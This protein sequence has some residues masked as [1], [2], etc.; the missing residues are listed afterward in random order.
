M[1]FVSDE[2]LLNR[3]AVIP[4]LIWQKNEKDRTE[5]K[6]ICKTNGHE[7]KWKKEVEKKTQSVYMCVSENI[8]H[9]KIHITT[10]RHDS[11]NRTN[12]MHCTKIDYNGHTEMKEKSRH[13]NGMLQNIDKATTLSSIHIWNCATVS[14]LR[15]KSTSKRRNHGVWICN[16]TNMPYDCVS[17][18]I[19]LN[20]GN[21]GRADFDSDSDV[22][23]WEVKRIVFHSAGFFSL[24]LAVKW[25]MGMGGQESIIRAAKRSKKLWELE[26]WEDGVMD[27]FAWKEIDKGFLFNEHR[28][29]SIECLSIFNDK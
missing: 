20:K 5:K 1:T 16:C 25:G 10:K 8:R 23:C 14:R 21:L 17:V 6:M 28:L 22:R 29:G 15:T 11:I 13:K 19:A 27:D 4:F 3:L 26:D 12:V 7:E 9:R 24:P 2:F 18:S